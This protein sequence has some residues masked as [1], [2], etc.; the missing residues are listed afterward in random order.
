[1]LFAMLS[2]QS[3][4]I[5]TAGNG[6]DGIRKIKTNNYSL[7]ITDIKMPGI[8]GAQVLEYTRNTLIK[9]PIKNRIYAQLMGL[10]TS[11]INGCDSK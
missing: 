2:R 1:M 3:L 11:D 10:G 7:I 8:T 9:I 6:E 5:D 4:K